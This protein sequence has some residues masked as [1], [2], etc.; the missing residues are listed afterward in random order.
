MSRGKS[1]EGEEIVKTGNDWTLLAWG[2]IVCRRG[3]LDHESYY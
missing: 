3:I 2:W 1:Q